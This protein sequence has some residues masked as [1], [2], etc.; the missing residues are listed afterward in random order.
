MFKWKNCIFYDYNSESSYD[1]DGCKVPYI[2]YFFHSEEPAASPDGRV[3]ISCNLGQDQDG[4][5]SGPFGL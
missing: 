2:I 1:L 4:Q 3:V 5:F